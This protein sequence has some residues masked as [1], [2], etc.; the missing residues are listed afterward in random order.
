MLRQ[1]ECHRLIQPVNMHAKGA[2][3]Q[4]FTKIQNFTLEKENFSFFEEYILF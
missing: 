4:K 2:F 1:R 3:D